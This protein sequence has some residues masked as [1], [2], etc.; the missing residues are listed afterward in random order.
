MHHSRPRD[1]GDCKI[2]NVSALNHMADPRSWLAWCYSMP[3]Q[4]SCAV[5]DVHMVRRREQTMLLIERDVVAPM[6]DISPKCALRHQSRLLVVDDLLECTIRVFIVS[7][8]WCEIGLSPT[9]V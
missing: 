9:A 5:L 2:G 6:S 1:K 3:V 4:M 8:D 7:C